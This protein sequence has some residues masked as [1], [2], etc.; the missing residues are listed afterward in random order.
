MLA[1][2]L[3]HWTEKLHYTTSKSYA[4]NL[5]QCLLIH[6]NFLFEYYVIESK[7]WLIIKNPN[8]LDHAQN[9]FKDTGIK[10]TC[11]GKRHLSAV[12]GSEDFKSEYV[13]EKITNW[14]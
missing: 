12:I 11:E 6:T 10:I 9:I 1:V 2:H 4:P 8:H 5:R 14:T 13:R 3:I 7:S